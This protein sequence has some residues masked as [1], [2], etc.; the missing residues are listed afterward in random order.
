MEIFTSYGARYRSP[1]LVNVSARLGTEML[2]R[3]SV[4]SGVGAGKRRNLPYKRERARR[5]EQANAP[6]ELTHVGRRSSIGLKN[7]RFAS[8]SWTRCR[9]A[10]GDGKNGTQDYQSQGLFHRD[11]HEWFNTLSGFAGFY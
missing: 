11:R 1:S 7:G 10:A 3:T 2:A 5:G 9:R 6:I 8:G 4:V